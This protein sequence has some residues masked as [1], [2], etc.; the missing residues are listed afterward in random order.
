MLARSGDAGV[1]CG[2]VVRCTAGTARCMAGAVWCTAGAA[3]GVASAG[4]PGSGAPRAGRACPLAGVGRP[5]CGA[6]VVRAGGTA[7]AGCTGSG[8][9]GLTGADGREGDAAAAGAW[10]LTGTAALPRAGAPRPGR[11]GALR[12]TAEVIAAPGELAPRAAGVTA[13]PGA[14]PTRRT[15][16][17]RAAGADAGGVFAVVPGAVDGVG[18]PVGLTAARAA[19]GGEVRSP[20]V[21]GAAWFVGADAADGAWATGFTVRS[22]AGPGARWTAGLGADGRCPD[23]FVAGLLG[24]TAV[25]S[26]AGAGADPVV[27]PGVRWTVGL[28]AVRTAGAGGRGPAG[29]AAGPTVGLDVSRVAGSAGRPLAEAD[30]DSAGSAVTGLPTGLCAV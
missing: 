8:D 15:F 19:G 7:G 25:R 6:A 13:E 11:R 1:G 24:G 9:C 10:P 12:W 27:G 18:V 28:L 2:G 22:L 30:A 5:V 14:G 23:E 20:K 4:R 26:P 29:P 16:A 17:A 21:P 3:T